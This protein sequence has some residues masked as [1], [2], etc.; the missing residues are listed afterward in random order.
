MTLQI[1]EA[2]KLL[3][4]EQ[5]EITIIGIFAVVIVGLAYA[6]VYF[7][8]KYNKAMEDR[9]LDHKKFSETLIEANEESNEIS[10]KVLLALE[11]LKTIINVSK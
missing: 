1:D 6:S 4:L 5:K 9:L 11:V 10:N 2:T 7:M 8:K 3:S